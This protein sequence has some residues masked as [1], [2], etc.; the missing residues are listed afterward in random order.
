MAESE[1]FWREH[2]A[3]VGAGLA[4]V[5]VVGVGAWLFFGGDAQPVRKVPEVMMVK[6]QPLPP[7]PPPPPK[8]IPQ[9]KMVEQTPVRINEPKP[10]KPIDQPKAQP[11]ADAP[12]PGP[13]ALDAKGEGPGDAFNLGGREGG[14]GLLGGGGGGSRWGWYAAIV[15][16][17]IEAALRAN[18]KT[19]NA[20]ARNEIRLW[21]DDRGRIERASLVTSTGDAEID[22]AIERDVLPG[23][24]F[25]QTPPKDMPMPVV[26]RLTARR[27]S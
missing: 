19:R 27:P 25:D 1:S 17:R 21:L 15:Q 12:P 11:K 23:L 8:E 14:N 4:V 24:A 22:R 18:P 16:T 10:E 5:G 13:L 9:P 3:A 7:P 6:L 2:G 26:V 20:Q